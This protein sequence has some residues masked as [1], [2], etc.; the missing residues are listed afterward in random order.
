MYPREKWDCLGQHAE[1]FT[2]LRLLL[3]VDA[4]HDVHTM[5]DSV[6]EIFR[7]KQSQYTFYMHTIDSTRSHR[8]TTVGEG[9]RPSCVHCSSNELIF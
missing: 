6:I 9:S 5:Y 2:F 8:P 1:E 3:R 4:I 7:L